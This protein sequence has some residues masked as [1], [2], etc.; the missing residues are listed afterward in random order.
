M[1]IG[2]VALL[3]SSLA[4]TGELRRIPLA[5][6]PLNKLPMVACFEF[7]VGRSDALL[8]YSVQDQSRSGGAIRYR[9]G[10]IPPWTIPKTSLMKPS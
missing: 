6:T 3:S 7:L 2:G 4:L 1:L 5:R 8:S 10:P 9:N